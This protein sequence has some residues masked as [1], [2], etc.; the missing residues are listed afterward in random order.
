MVVMLI[1]LQGFK[2]ALE[3]A[4]FPLVTIKQHIEDSSPAGQM[5][6]DVQQF[7]KRTAPTLLSI[8]PAAND[9]QARASPLPGC[10]THPDTKNINILKHLFPFTRR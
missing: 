1:S 6:S 5:H 10:S 3:R 8:S 9:L 4:L 7:F 2:A